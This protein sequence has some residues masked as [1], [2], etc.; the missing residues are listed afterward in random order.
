MLKRLKIE[1]DKKDDSE[2]RSQLNLSRQSAKKVPTFSRK[3][4]TRMMIKKPL[5]AN[6]RQFKVHDLYA[7]NPNIIT[8]L[9]LDQMLA[10]NAETPEV[11][12]MRQVQ[13]TKN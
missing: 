5:T 12:S 11:P 10:A 2:Q 3:A 4:S 13:S 9:E 7:S 6:L 1:I 8:E